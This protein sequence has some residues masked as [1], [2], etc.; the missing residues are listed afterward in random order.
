MTPEGRIQAKIIKYLK[1]RNI[2]HFRYNAVSSSFGLPDIIG[3]Y[4]GTFIGLE[5]KT[6][7]GRPTELQLKMQ[8]MIREA[9]GVYEFVTSVEEA[10]RAIENA[11]KTN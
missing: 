5:V 3:I 8:E 11:D 1:E 4:K 7:K 9:G 2:F 6:P 10:E